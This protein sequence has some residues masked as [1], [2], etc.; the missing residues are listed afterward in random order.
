[1]PQGWYWRYESFFQDIAKACQTAPDDEWCVP[2]S[3]TTQTLRL[4]S[5]FDI[6]VSKSSFMGFAWNLTGE[7]YGSYTD[8]FV[9][10]ISED[11]RDAAPTATFRI[12]SRDNCDS[13]IACGDCQTDTRGL[14]IDFAGRSFEIGKY[15]SEEDADLRVVSVQSLDTGWSIVYET[16]SG[17]YPQD[18]TQID[19]ECTPSGWVALMTTRCRRYVDGTLVSDTTDQWAGE[20]QCYESCDGFYDAGSG[21]GPFQVRTAGEPI[22]LGEP[23]NVEYLGRESSAVECEPPGRPDFTVRQVE[24]C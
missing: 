18:T 20:M 1:V 12:T 3:F 19:L 24:F 2:P 7:G 17:G 21:E 10:T 4:P 11:F 5:P 22:P 15:I 23:Q 16:R 6:N 9:K 13:P 8:P 14:I